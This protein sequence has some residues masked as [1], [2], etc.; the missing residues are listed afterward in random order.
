MTMNLY[1]SRHFFFTFKTDKKERR[2]FATQKLTYFTY[3]NQETINAIFVEGFRHG[4][5]PIPSRTYMRA[6]TR[7][8]F[9]L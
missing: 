3:F 4:R 8:S 6:G 7:Q 5:S 1:F 9:V 2:Q